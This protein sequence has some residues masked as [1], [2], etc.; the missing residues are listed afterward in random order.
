MESIAETFN[1]QRKEALN[2]D[3]KQTWEIKK[4]KKQSGKM[5][6]GKWTVFDTFQKVKAKVKKKS[7]KCKN[8]ALSAFDLISAA[9]GEDERYV[10]DCVCQDTLFIST[11][12]PGMA[13][14]SDSSVEKYV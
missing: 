2:R 13:I 9:Q 14:R 4:S 12:G 8:R 1:F 6:V 7:Q 3:G 10:K 5:K 11:H